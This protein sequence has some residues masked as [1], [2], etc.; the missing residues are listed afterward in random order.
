MCLVAPV[1]PNSNVTQTHCRDLV[2]RLFSKVK[3]V[4]TSFCNTLAATLNHGASHCGVQCVA[5]SPRSCRRACPDCRLSGFPWRLARG[6]AVRHLNIRSLSDSRSPHRRSD[7]LAWTGSPDCST[8]PDSDWR[9]KTS[10]T[11]SGRQ[12]DVKATHK[13]MY[14]QN[15]S[16]ECG[17]L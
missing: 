5:A 10:N 2:L 11:K 4:T 14:Q 6:R 15:S 7:P 8:G 16:G 17:V 9:I 12:I 13:H 3:T 1:N